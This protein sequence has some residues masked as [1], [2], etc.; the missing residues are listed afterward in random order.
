MVKIRDCR[1]D[2]GQEKKGGKETLTGAP[3]LE[4]AIGVKKRDSLANGK[5]TREKLS[6]IVQKDPYLQGSKVG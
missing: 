1:L 4:R 6:I 2:H 5:K 3:N